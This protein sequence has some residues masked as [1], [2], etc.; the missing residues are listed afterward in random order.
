MR[1]FDNTCLVDTVTH[2]RRELEGLSGAVAFET[3][4]YVLY[5]TLAVGDAGAKVFLVLSCC[6]SKEEL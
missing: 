6:V 2:T 1:G 3:V 5:I 4:L